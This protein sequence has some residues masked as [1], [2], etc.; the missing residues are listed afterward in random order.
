[1]QSLLK[2]ITPCGWVLI[3]TELFSAGIIDVNAFGVEK[4]ACCN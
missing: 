2:K 3:T 1:M 4:Y